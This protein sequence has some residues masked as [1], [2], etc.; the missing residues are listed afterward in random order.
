MKWLKFETKLQYVAIQDNLNLLFDGQ[1]TQMSQ[2]LELF[3][4]ANVFGALIRS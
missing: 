2:V 1:T 3:L 4:L